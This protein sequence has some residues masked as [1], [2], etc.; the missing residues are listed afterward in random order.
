M[1]LRT[2]ASIIF[3]DDTSKKQLQS[4]LV[5]EN[6][7][8]IQGNSVNEEKNIGIFIRKGETILCYH[9]GFSILYLDWY[10]NPWNILNEGLANDW[11][12]IVYE[13]L[14]V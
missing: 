1:L 6:V 7:L 10:K 3:K 9:F 13:L 8:K 12:Y 2:R 14:K 11:N 4:P 5:L